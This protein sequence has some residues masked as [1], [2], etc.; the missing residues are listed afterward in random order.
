MKFIKRKRGRV[1]S[2]GLTNKKQS[3]MEKL[4]PPGSTINLGPRRSRSARMLIGNLFQQ[5]SWTTPIDKPPYVEASFQYNVLPKLFSLNNPW[6]A[7]SINA[8]S[9][10]HQ[11]G[12]ALTLRPVA[13]GNMRA[14]QASTK[15][16]KSSCT[17]AEITDSV[18]RVVELFP[19]GVLHNIWQLNR[20]FCI[21]KDRAGKLRAGVRRRCGNEAVRRTATNLPNRNAWNPGYS[22][23]VKLCLQRHGF[24]SVVRLHGMATSPL[25]QSMC[26]IYENTYK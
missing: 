2:F 18:T 22:A 23:Q 25:V 24:L 7:S 12:D 5:T 16:G 21:P 8:V 4:Q 15:V 19:E 3:N 13:L 1:W 9:L 11:Q 14:R 17:V 26:G 6:C 10:L 20:K